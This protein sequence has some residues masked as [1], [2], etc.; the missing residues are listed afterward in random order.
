M[1]NYLERGLDPDALEKAY[2]K[3]KGELPSRIEDKAKI[4]GQKQAVEQIFNSPDHQLNILAHQLIKEYD[5]AENVAGALKNA[6]N[7]YSKKLS[8]LGYEDA[9]LLAVCHKIEEEKFK[10]VHQ[11]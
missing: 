9:L 8:N 2:K 6:K 3:Q 11:V 10:N 4:L 5:L 7:I 1:S